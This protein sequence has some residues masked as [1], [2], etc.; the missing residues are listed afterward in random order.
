MARF[1]KE[2]KDTI[3]SDQE[4]FGKNSE[5]FTLILLTGGD[6][7]EH[8]EQSVEEHINECGDWFKKLIADCGGRYRVFNNRDKGNTTQ[9]SE[10]IDKINNMVT[11]RTTGSC[12]TN[13]MF[14]EAEQAIQKEVERTP[15][16]KEE[17]MR[18]E[19]E[20]IQRTHEEAMEKMEERIKESEQ[21]RKEKEK[22]LEHK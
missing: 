16:E 20:E 22:E 13:D 4:S 12:Y 5:R 9:V 7:L 15:K 3:T 8:E 21:N 2:E 18:R 19:R 11:D 14:Q 6:T 1:T 10:L 17:E